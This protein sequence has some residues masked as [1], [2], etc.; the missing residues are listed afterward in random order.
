MALWKIPMGPIFP[1]A[2]EIII[3]NGIE[4]IKPTEEKVQSKVLKPKNAKR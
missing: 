2:G 1:V 3:E 4:F